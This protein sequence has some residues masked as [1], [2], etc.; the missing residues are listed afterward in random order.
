MDRLLFQYKFQGRGNEHDH[1]ILWI[2][3]VLLYKV[4]SNE[5]IGTFV[6]KYIFVIKSLLSLALQETQCHQHF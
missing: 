2:Q 5:E 1:G 4:K 3:N 6:Y